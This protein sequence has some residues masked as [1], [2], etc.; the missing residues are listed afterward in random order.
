MLIIKLFPP[1]V[2]NKHQPSNVGMIAAMKVVYRMIMLT[3]LLNIF[4]APPGGYKQAV[5]M[6]W[7]QDK[8]CSGLPFGGKATVVTQC[9]VDLAWMIFG[10]LMESM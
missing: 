8:G 2:T 6:G 1:K 3:N 4:D 9:Y 7:L 5:C 10:K